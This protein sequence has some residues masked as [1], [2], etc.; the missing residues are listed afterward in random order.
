MFLYC[1]LILIWLNTIYGQNCKYSLNGQ[2]PP[3]DEPIIYGKGIISNDT[4]GLHGISFSPKGDEL[5]YSVRTEG[6]YYMKRE[7]DKWTKPNLMDFSKKSL[8]H[9]MYPKFSPDGNF[10]SFVDGNSK[11]YNFGDI[12]K[13]TR[14]SDNTWS[15]AIKLPSPINI[16]G[17][18]AGH[19]FTLNGNLYFTSGRA[20]SIGNNDVFKA[21]LGDNGKIEI[22]LLNTISQYCIFTDEEC[23]YVSPNEEFIITDSWR[24]RSKRK[25]DLFIAYRLDNNDWSELTPLNTQINT[26]N[27][28]NAPFVTSDNKYLFFSRGGEGITNFYWV[29]TKK[30]FTP[31]LNLQIPDFFEKVN[32]EI[33]IEFPRNVFEDYNGEIVDYTLKVNGLDNL[34]EY[35]DFDKENLVIKGKSTKPEVLKCQ[36]IAFD[37]DGNVGKTDFEIIIEE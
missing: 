12:Y 20:D 14:Q 24:K 19:C 36:L 5:I 6:V 29:S 16:K 1:T 15:D 35:I 33:K 28:E 7:G 4:L 30:I 34:P 21:V 17:R 31:Y 25:H 18:D 26:E 10:I 22:K 9:I 32:T 27:F 23:L 8:T 3:E 2:I 13:I 37:N 11:Q